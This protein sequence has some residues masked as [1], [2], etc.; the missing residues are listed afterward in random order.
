MHFAFFIP[1]R[2]NCAMRN[3]ILVY[4]NGQR[5][6]VGGEA[7]FLSLSDY[8][9]KECNLPGTK[10]VCSEG[11]CGA[12][13]VLIGRVDAVAPDRLTYD[14]IDSCI[15]FLYQLDRTHVVSV[16]ALAA[17]D[18]LHPVQQEM[19]DGFGSQCGFC[20]PGFVMAMAG[21]TEAR[22]AHAIPQLE[23]DDWRLGL[24]GNLCRCTGYVQILESAQAVDA[25]QVVSLNT[26]FPAEPMLSDFAS[27]GETPVEI[28][29]GSPRQR[30]V[31]IPTD[32]AGAVAFKAAH[33]ESRIVNGATD[34][35][36]VYNKGRIDP[37]SILCLRNVKEG[38]N[39]EVVNGELH[40]G[41]RAT[42]SEIERWAK[43]GWPE[44]YKIIIR[45]GSPQIRNASTLI[46]NI[47]NASPI[48]DSLPL[49]HVMHA[50]VALTGPQGTREVDINDFYRG[51]KQLDLQA[52][53]LI[54]SVTIPL[55]DEKDRL[56]L[57]K[58]SR[59]NDMDIS[60]FTAAVRLTC[61]GDSIETARIAYGGVGP[62][63]MRLPKAEASLSGVP[64]SESSL[65]Q[66]GKLARTEITPIS[67]VR[68]EAEYR[69]QL[70]ENILLKCYFELTGE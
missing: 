6:E 23:E 39:V 54:S 48:A 12:C 61:Q 36:V 26:Q 44:F 58:V 57:Y 13:S 20:T 18:Q 15:C 25:A 3:S 24:T 2:Y 37:S 46:G 41:L 28:A 55:P 49:L 70:A 40:V 65:R 1:H 31:S 27:A 66:A 62:V 11:D 19:I 8:L 68:S 43:E 22:A 67:D 29:C 60:T 52:D 63:V 30:T 47:A 17:G 45:F 53:E 16:D 32:L 56:K 7:A 4:I 42:W 5:H 35:G 34:V 38:S 59:R 14:A 51:Y 21:L 33:P 10:I 9:R 69:Y 50:R 64:L